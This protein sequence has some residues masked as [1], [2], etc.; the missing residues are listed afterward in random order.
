[1]GISMAYCDNDTNDQLRDH[2]FSGTPVDGPNNNNSYIYASIFGKFILGP[3]A[4]DTENQTIQNNFK[5]YPNPINNQ[6]NIE[7]LNNT[8]NYFLN[9]FDTNGRLIIQQNINQTTNH[10][11]T[12]NLAKGIYTYNI[13]EENQIINQGKIIK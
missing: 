5:I 12:Q 10:T 7:I 9:V 13:S 11:N 8:E 6:L 4:L 2:F 3:A 1:M